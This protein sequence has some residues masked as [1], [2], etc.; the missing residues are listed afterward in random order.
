MHIKIHPHFVVVVV[1]VLF[2]FKNQKENKNET[3]NKT[4]INCENCP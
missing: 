3:V 2:P 1:V 4:H